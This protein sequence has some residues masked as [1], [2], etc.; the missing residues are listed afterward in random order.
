[1]W[2]RLHSSARAWAVRASLA[3]SPALS[4][5]VSPGLSL[6]LPRAL[7]V[8]SHPL[9]LS[10]PAA[11]PHAGSAARRALGAAAGSSTHTGRPPPAACRPVRG[12]RG[13]AL[14]GEERLRE[15]GCRRASGGGEDHRCICSESAPQESTEGA[16]V[17]RG[18][19]PA[20]PP[21]QGRQSCQFTHWQRR[22]K[23][24]GRGEG[25]EKKKKKRERERRSHLSPKRSGLK[26]C[27]PNAELN[28]DW[29]LWKGWI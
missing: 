14:R 22:G 26:T 4:A 21:R 1:M 17:Q 20:P 11:P 16:R 8:S 29:P 15:P 23:E 2:R 13:S 12:M 18:E 25:K 10:F 6:P 19:N 7:P 5:R 28:K 27:L 3:R 9:R 24:G